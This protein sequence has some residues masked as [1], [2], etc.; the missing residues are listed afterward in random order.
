MA[1]RTR[2]IV[3]SAINVL[4]MVNDNLVKNRR[5]GLPGVVELPSLRRRAYMIVNETGLLPV[6][7]LEDEPGSDFTR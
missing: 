5:R 6:K 3:P 4:T 7:E 2:V 1:D